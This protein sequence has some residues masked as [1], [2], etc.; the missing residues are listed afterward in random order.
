MTA[1]TDT[2]A[3]SI[4]YIEDETTISSL[5]SKHLARAHFSVTTFASADCFLKSLA[6]SPQHIESYDLYILDLLLPGSAS[7]WDLCRQIRSESARVPILILSALAEVEDRIQGFRLGADDYLVKPFDIEELLLRV[8][9]MIKRTQWYDR[10]PQNREIYRWQENSINFL[11]YQGSHGGKSFSLTQK[12]CMILKLFIERE[13]EVVARDEILNY[14]WGYHVYPSARTVD[15]FILRLRKYFE[16]NPK[17][18][19]YL[20]SI[21]GVGY[22]FTSKPEKSIS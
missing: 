6:L 10:F 15:N 11:T 20:H 22:R 2:I 7:G 12:E 5:V 17:T 16:K 13:G 19:H 18:P 8:Q 21:R 14:V 9:A 3:P 4:C 1:P